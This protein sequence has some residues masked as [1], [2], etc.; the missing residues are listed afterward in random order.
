[1]KG[2]LES[3]QHSDMRIA[4]VLF[5]F[6]AIG[7][8]LFFTT[9]PSAHTLVLENVK[10]DTKELEA[11]RAGRYYNER[12]GFSFSAPSGARI[13][14]RKEGPDAATIRIEDE[15]KG[16]GFQ[17]FVIAYSGKTISD[18]RFRMD[19]PSGVRNQEEAIL[20]A[21]VPA[22]AFKSTDT[23][24]GETREVWLLREGY[25]Y[26]ITA[27]ISSEAWLQEVMLTWNF[28]KISH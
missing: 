9:R 22:V 27:P 5:A 28:E 12:Y 4:A 3:C 7:A 13:H 11:E 26:E 2:K 16:M 1:M 21:G 20:L 25:L 15:Q 8:F 19:L 14:E 17:V 18:E 24:L 23:L 6:A 10:I